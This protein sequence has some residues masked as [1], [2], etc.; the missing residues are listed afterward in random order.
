[1]ISRFVSAKDGAKGNRSFSIDA[2]SLRSRW[3]NSSDIEKCVGTCDESVARDERDKHSSASKLA[4]AKIV[5][6]A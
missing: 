5:T 6:P 1:M 2:P 3:N 4:R